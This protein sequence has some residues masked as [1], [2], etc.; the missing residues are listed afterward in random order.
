LFD[1]ESRDQLVAFRSAHGTYIGV[2]SGGEKLVCSSTTVGPSELFQIRLRAYIQANSGH[3]I[4]SE[5]NHTLTAQRFKPGIARGDSFIL[6]VGTARCSFRSQ[7][8]RSARLPY[9]PFFPSSTGA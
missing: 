7:F 2:E 3:Y 9:M 4:S 8:N 6:E 5:R 1:V